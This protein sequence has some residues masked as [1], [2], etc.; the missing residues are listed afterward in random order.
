MNHPSQVDATD[1]SGV[2]SGQA[3][4]GKV[5]IESI[6]NQRFKAE[7]CISRHTHYTHAE[8]IYLLKLLPQVITVCD[9][10]DFCAEMRALNCAVWTRMEWQGTDAAWSEVE[11]RLPPF[12]IGKYTVTSY[13]PLVWSCSLAMAAVCASTWKNARLMNPT[14]PTA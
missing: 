12:H 11:R 14:V 6:G 8:T 5:L 10:N 2:M 9:V 7:L 13:D 3:S 4:E 1:K